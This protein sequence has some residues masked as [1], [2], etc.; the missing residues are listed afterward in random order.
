MEVYTFGGPGG[1]SSAGGDAADFRTFLND[2]T[3]STL[4]A[5]RLGMEAWIAVNREKIDDVVGRH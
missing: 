4:R 3:P 5:K 1:Q 2:V